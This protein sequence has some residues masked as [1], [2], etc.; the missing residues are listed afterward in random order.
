MRTIVLKDFATP[1]K[2]TYSVNEAAEGNPSFDM[3][4]PEG[5]LTE[6]DLLDLGLHK[7]VEQI[8]Q[9][10]SA[11]YVNSLDNESQTVQYGF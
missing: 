8:N 7:L 2:V 11:D 9:R 6:R 5:I 4:T 1:I 10:I 3:H